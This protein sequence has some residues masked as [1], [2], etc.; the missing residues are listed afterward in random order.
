MTNINKSKKNSDSRESGKFV[1]SEHE[2]LREIKASQIV[3]RYM[4]WSM[5]TG[6]I[7]VPLLDTAVLSGVQLKMLSSLSSFYKI[8]FSKNMGKSV[9][10]VLA[11]FSTTNVV[12]GGFFS[13]IKVLPGVGFWGTVSMP[14]YAGAMTYAIGKLFIQHFEAGGTFLTFK[15]Y[16][17]KKYFAQLIE[18]GRQIAANLQEEK[19]K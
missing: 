10:A 5:G 14:I 7:P 19:G 4:L 15:P 9:I 11:G 6:L 1:I 2:E 8:P 17:V 18:D 13:L 12:R 3:R 16:K